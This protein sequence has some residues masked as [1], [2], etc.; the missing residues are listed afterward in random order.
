MKAKEKL[1]KKVIVGFDCTTSGRILTANRISSFEE[2]EDF[3][4][5]S[6]NTHSWEILLESDFEELFAHMKVGV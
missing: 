5:G 2:A 6:P 4:E 3:V 1:E